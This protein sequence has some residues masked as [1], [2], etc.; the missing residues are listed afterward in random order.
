MTLCIIGAD[1]A[2]LKKNEEAIQALRASLKKNP[3]NPL[4]MFQYANILMQLNE[5]KKAIAVLEKINLLEY[6]TPIK[7]QSKKLLAQIK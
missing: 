3:N 5:R 6:F 4:C 7:E 1:F 2:Q